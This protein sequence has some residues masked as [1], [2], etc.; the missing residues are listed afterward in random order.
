MSELESCSTGPMRLRKR[1]TIVS[2]ENG[3]T[4]TTETGQIF[5]ARNLEDVLTISRD[6]L[7]KGNDPVEPRN[8]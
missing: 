5:V 3:Y 2:C 7:T 1:L 6:S 8:D 4:V